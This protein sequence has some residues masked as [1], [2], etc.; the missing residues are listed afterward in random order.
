MGHVVIVVPQQHWRS[1]TLYGVNI[2]KDH[3]IRGYVSYGKL[4]SSQKNDNLPLK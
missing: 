2:I 1:S 4:L 3:C